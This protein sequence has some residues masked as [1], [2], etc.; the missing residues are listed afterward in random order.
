MRVRL[1]REFRV[2]HRGEV[3]DVAPSAARA[4]IEAGVAEAVPDAEAEPSR[5]QRGR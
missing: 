3:V 4:W 5:R 1:L 2:W